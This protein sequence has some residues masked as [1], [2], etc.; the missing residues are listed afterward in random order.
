MTENNKKDKKIL[1]VP[2]IFAILLFLTGTVMLVNG[3]NKFIDAE[4]QYEIEMEQYERDKDDWLRNPT[5]YGMP[6]FPGFGPSFPFLGVAGG[7]LMALSI[8]FLIVGFSPAL[9]KKVRQYQKNLLNKTTTQKQNNNI[10]L[11][12]FLSEKQKNS[13]CAYCG[14]IIPHN[15]TRCDSCGANVKK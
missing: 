4:N 8:P 6:E 14:A 10:D 9:D 11:F 2:I 13:T 15:K 1:I 12:N 3:I 5:H 7:V